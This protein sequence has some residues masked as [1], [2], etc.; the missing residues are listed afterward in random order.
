M[1][2]PLHSLTCS[3]CCDLMQLCV[4]EKK[5]EKRKTRTVKV[6]VTS[7]WRHVFGEKTLYSFQH[8]ASVNVN[9]VH[10]YWFDEEALK[11]DSDFSMWKLAT[12]A[13]FRQ[14]KIFGWCFCHVTQWRRKHKP[15]KQVANVNSHV[16]WV[17]GTCCVWMWFCT[18]RHFERFVNTT[19]RL[20][21][22]LNKKCLQKMFPVY[23][24]SW[25][26]YTFKHLMN[27]FNADG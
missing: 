25:Y 15:P 17:V 24:N 2:N 12:V 13:R 27:Y 9:C 20:L 1:C 21:P 26:N 18:F 4:I 19:K 5:K 8:A 3:L 7:E 16:G 23:L 6:A 14:K 11:A 10:L 22:V